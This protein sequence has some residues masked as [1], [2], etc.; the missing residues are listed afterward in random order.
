[1]PTGPLGLIAGYSYG[2][3]SEKGLKI[4]IN[5]V[6]ATTASLLGAG[7]L[8]LAYQQWYNTSS[9]NPRRGD[10]FL[11]P[12]IVGALVG[13]AVSLGYC[14]WGVTDIFRTV[15]AQGRLSR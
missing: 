2:G 13:E 9:P 12:V 8:T 5:G 3:E 11:F 6:A 15:Q 1:M 4:G 14:L 10:G 7:A